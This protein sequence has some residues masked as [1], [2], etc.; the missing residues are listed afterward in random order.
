MIDEL[1]QIISQETNLFEE[2][3]TLLEKQKEMLV[4]NDVD[5]VTKVTRRQQ[6]TLFES[7]KLNHA[8]IKLIAEIRKENDINEDITVSQLLEYADESQSE[9]LLQLKELIL[10]LNDRITKA[11]N[12]NAILLNQSRQF[13]SRTM[14]MLAQLNHPEATYCQSQNSRTVPTETQNVVLDRRF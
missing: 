2:F 3:L 7:Q 13:I 1:I 4:T 12:T 5:G 8:R 14:E 9:R 10:E 6:E 11:R